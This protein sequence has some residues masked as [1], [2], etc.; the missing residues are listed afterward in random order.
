MTREEKIQKLID[1]GCT[2]DPIT[3]KIFGSSGRELKSTMN[4]YI[5]I[6][7]RENGIKY[8]LLGHQFMYYWV[9]NKCV[10]LIDHINRNKLDNRISNLRESNK[11]QNQQNIEYLGY[12]IKGDRFQTQIMINGKSKYIG[13]FN[14]EQEASK[15]YLDAKKIYHNI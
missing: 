8:K 5:V 13:L 11:S 10:D 9:Y 12:S 2:C 3:G 1:R 7:F 14:T 4:G 15:A 6:H